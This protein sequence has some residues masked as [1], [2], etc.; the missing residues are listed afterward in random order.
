MNKQDVAVWIVRD[1]DLDLDLT[2]PKIEL[3]QLIFM[4]EAYLNAALQL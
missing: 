1:L 2:T 3:I 4:H